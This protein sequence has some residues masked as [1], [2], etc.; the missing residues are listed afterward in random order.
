M[1]GQLAVRSG[2]WKLV[3]LSKDQPF[4]LYDLDQ[5]VKESND[6]ASRYPDR[7]DALRLS[8]TTWNDRNAP[9]LW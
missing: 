9:P 1:G 4:R 7:V 2:R 8:L 5:D 6:L 3:R